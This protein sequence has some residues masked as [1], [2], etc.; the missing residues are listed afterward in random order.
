[1]E[2]GQR[3][4]IG[5]M[6]TI[7]SAVASHLI[8]LT[9]RQERLLQELMREIVR[10]TAQKQPLQVGVPLYPFSHKTLFSRDEAPVLSD[11]SSGSVPPYDEQEFLSHRSSRNSNSSNGPLAGTSWSQRGISSSPGN[12]VP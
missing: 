4:P 9:A 5:S 2:Y 7:S 3:S 6:S 12:F 8:R 11:D 10:M 1:M